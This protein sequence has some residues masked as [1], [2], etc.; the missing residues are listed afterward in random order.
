[1]RSATR[2]APLRLGL[3][4]AALLVMA[5]QETPS[6]SQPAAVLAALHGQV[7]V[8]RPGAG[9]PIP[10]S[11]GMRL[12]AGDT[13][14]AGAGS[15][16][17]LYLPGGGIVRVPAGNRI[18]IPRRPEKTP[19]KADAIAG[20]SG[21]SLKMLESGLWVLNDPQGSLLLSGMRGGRDLWGQDEE[22]GPSLLAP[23]YETVTAQRPVFYWAGHS[24]RARVVV[25]R[26][27][28]GEIL[29]RSEPIPPGAIPY[30]GD[31]PP[32][33][34]SEAYRWWLEPAAE[35]APLTSRVPF[36]MA[37]QEVAAKS[38]KFEAEL[39]GLS[40]AADGPAVEDFM[41]CAFYLE[42]GDWTRTLAAAAHLRGLHPDSD[43]V[44]R[45]LSG[46]RLQ[47]RLDEE[48]LEALL[49]LQGRSPE[50][51]SVDAPPVR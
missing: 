37:S 46:A 28:A 5:A 26:G 21:S 3:A 11:L 22:A 4:A 14:R 24:E 36:R 15:S 10:G 19:V 44:K 35:G 8:D 17:T 45:A 34:S 42:A 1:M 32:L 49:D 25:G 18:E 43:L 47:M 39:A 12:L 40:D 50:P 48:D 29:W 41:R 16:A 27:Q 23:R 31:A 20:M 9:Q 7:A 51:P 33:R 13:V 30:P 38:A 6:T 2:S